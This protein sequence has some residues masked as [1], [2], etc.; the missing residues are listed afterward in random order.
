MSVKADPVKIREIAAKIKKMG[1]KGGE[2]KQKAKDADIDPYLWGALG[3]ATVMLPVMYNSVSDEIYE[4]LDMMVEGFESAVTKLGK[5]ADA[6]EHD[7]NQGKADL[8]SMRTI[9]EQRRGR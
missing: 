7:D 4:H 5:C 3:Y 2:T 8:D 1:E 6:Y 9:L